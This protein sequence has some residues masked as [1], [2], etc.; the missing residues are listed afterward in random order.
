MKPEILF[1][2]IY[3]LRPVVTSR[4]YV[5]VLRPVV[6]SRCYVPLLRPVVKKKKACFP[7]VRV[8]LSENKEFRQHLLRG[9][10][11][12]HTGVAFT[13]KNYGVYYLWAG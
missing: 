5:Q 8:L 10:G 11:T 7:G 1:C 13:N 4:C 2:C 9:S 12:K 3:V 6:T